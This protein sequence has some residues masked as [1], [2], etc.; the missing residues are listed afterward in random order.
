MRSLFYNDIDKTF[1]IS[2][3]RKFYKNHIF[4]LL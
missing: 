4:D 3:V 1:F 2:L